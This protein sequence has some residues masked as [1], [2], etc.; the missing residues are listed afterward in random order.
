MDEV[1]KLREKYSGVLDNETLDFIEKETNKMINNSNDIKKYK[2]IFLNNAR[3]YVLGGFDIEASKKF[4]DK[5]FENLFMQKLND[6]EYFKQ[7][8]SFFQNFKIKIDFEIILNIVS[9]T[10]SFKKYLESI[11]NKYKEY[12][13]NDRSNE[14][15]DDELFCLCID[16]FLEING[17]EKNANEITSQSNIQNLDSTNMFMHEIY[18]YKLLTKEE[19]QEYFI[20]L[21]KGMTEYRNKIIEHNLR[22]VVSVAKKYIG[23]SSLSFLDLVQEGTIGLMKAIKLFDYT[24]NYKFSTYATWRIRQAI[25]AAVASNGQTIPLPAWLQVNKR[26][27]DLAYYKLKEDLGRNPSISEL[28]LETT[29][30]EKQIE[31]YL[32]LPEISYSLDAKIRL[33]TEECYGDFIIDETQNVE[34]KAENSLVL[35]YIEKLMLEAG[36]TDQ[37]RKVLILYMGLY[38]M[39]E[40]TLEEIGKIENLTRERVRQIKLKALNKIRKLKNISSFAIYTDNPD[41]SIQY[42]SNFKSDLYKNMNSH[43]NLKRENRS[44]KNIYEYFKEY[45]SDLIDKAIDSITDLEKEMLLDVYGDLN[46]PYRYNLPENRSKFYNILY[47]V[48]RK[49]KKY[50]YD[51]GLALLK[52]VK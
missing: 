16:V 23:V 19:E 31:N 14:V 36:L 33:E 4:L 22:L 25:S 37:E 47:K 27:F 39:D 40:H 52:M 2:L 38:G 49:L 8:S 28:V 11:F 51:E 17:I 42:I 26:R 15:L 13:I 29:F 43:E 10:A 48:E 24:K 35:D 32:H 34:E 45:S 20:N 12:I 9:N 7:I 44:Y 6:I 18:K 46:K 21:S 3:K 41:M 1:S 30:T 5:Y 50:T